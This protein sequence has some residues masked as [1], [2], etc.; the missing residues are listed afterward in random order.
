VKAL[1]LIFA[2][3]FSMSVFADFEKRKPETID[4]NQRIEV[5]QRHSKELQKEIEKQGFGTRPQAK[6]SQKQKVIDLIDAELGWGEAPQVVGR[7]F[8]SVE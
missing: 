8:N 6:S 3:L 1:S 5:N 2:T 7:R 4:F